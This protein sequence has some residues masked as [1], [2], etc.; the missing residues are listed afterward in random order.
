MSNALKIAKL[1]RLF[2]AGNATNQLG[3]DGAGAPVQVPVP[4]GSLGFRN[5]I[6][7]G[8]FTALQVINQRG[9]AARNTTSNA[10]NYDRWFYHSTNTTLTQAIESLS[11]KASTTYTLNWVGTATCEYIQSASSM[12]TVVAAVGWTAIAKGAQL[13]TSATTVSAGLNLFV[14]F[15]GVT[16]DLAT[17][18]LAQLEEGSVATPFEQ[19]PY[20]TELSLCKRYFQVVH[21]VAGLASG[22][23][24]Y[25]CVINFPVMMRSTPAVTCTAAIVCADGSFQKTGASATAFTGTSSYGS[26]NTGGFTG[27]TSNAAYLGDSSSGYFQLD[28]EL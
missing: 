14:R 11:L 21:P 1:A 28:A 3:V 12:A 22:T 27:L 8:N 18:D 25:A 26:F 6:I 20:G 10:Y 9:V 4:S 2:A 5:K 23:L 15:I 16:A 19:R 7:N 24:N 17:L 13:T